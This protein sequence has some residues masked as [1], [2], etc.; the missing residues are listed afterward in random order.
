MKLDGLLSTILNNLRTLPENEQIIRGRINLADFLGQGII[1]NGQVLQISF[2]STNSMLNVSSIE[3]LKISAPL[4]SLTIEKILPQTNEHTVIEAKVSSIQNN[5]AD[6]QVL[7]INKQPVQQYI[8]EQINVTIP[9]KSINTAIIKDTNGLNN[10]S[11]KNISA[12][13]FISLPTDIHILPE[14]AKLELQSSLQRINIKFG[15]DAL[16]STAHKNIAQQIQT[17][18]YP[19]NQILAQTQHNVDNIIHVMIH[20]II[21]N[22]QQ[23]SEIIDASVQNIKS[24]LQQI[25]GISLPAYSSTTSLGETVFKTVLGDIKPEVI[26]Q[27]PQDLEASIKITDITQ[28]T[29]IIKIKADTQQEKILQVLEPLKAQNI[30][31]YDKIISKLPAAGNKMLSNISAFTKA[32]AQGDIKQWLGADIIQELDNN[33]AQGKAIISDLQSALQ[34]SNRNTP[35]WRIIEI[36]FYVENHIDKIKLAIKQ[37]PEDDKK[38]PESKDKFGTR[39][40]VDTEF[41]RLGGFQFDGFSF[42]KDRRFDLVIRTQK[43]IDDD[44]YA[45]IIKIF[46]TT[47]HD[48]Q[49]VGNIKINLKENF[50]KIS[51]NNTG[52]KF[53]SQDLFV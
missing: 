24:L 52:D 1:K 15:L 27:L 42:A 4:S 11:L 2:D 43:N 10:V 50:I 37:Y 8:K 45:N 32:S 22:P 3:G 38:N 6:I 26:L 39:F 49:Y 44:L 25:I 20:D 53:I 9:D 12:D 47:L 30:Q 14:Q 28:D 17:Q 21:A 46:K 33:G 18:S 34:G 5:I 51:E 31:L 19:A 36:P 40:V 7:N 35:L 23:T 29:S 13:M 41:T 48:L 16:S